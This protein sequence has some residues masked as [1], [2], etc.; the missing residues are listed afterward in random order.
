MAP[1][2]NR[3]KTN[4]VKPVPKTAR[5]KKTQRKRARVVMPDWRVFVRPLRNLVLLGGVVGICVVSW[6]V[7]DRPVTRIAVTA[8]FQRVTPMQIEDHVRTTLSG[9]ILSGDLSGVRESLET[10][11]WIDSVRIRRRWPTTLLVDVTEQVAAARWGATGLLN[12]RGELFVENARHQPAELPVL[13][14]PEGSQWQVAQR[15]LT[16]RGPLLEAGLQLESVTLDKRGSWHLLMARGIEVRFG[17]HTVDQRIDRFLN[18]VTPMIAGRTEVVDYID[19][20]YTNGFAIGWNEATR[21]AAQEPK[22]DGDP[23]V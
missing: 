16:L 11:P 12:T 14:G 10:L 22:D 5:R 6:H 2:L 13:N 23:D 7:F 15:Y 1:L 3:K 21:E 20:R 17:R 8:P 18:V 4:R 9:G 19:L